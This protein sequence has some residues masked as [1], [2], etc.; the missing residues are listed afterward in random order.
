MAMMVHILARLRLGRNGGSWAKASYS[1]AAG[2]GAGPSIDAAVRTGAGSRNG[3][4]GLSA[5]EGGGFHSA[6]GRAASGGGGCS[7]LCRHDAQRTC[8]PD[9]PIALSGTT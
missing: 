4:G 3:G 7:Q 8:R 1:S 2:V 9:G 5:A 6:A